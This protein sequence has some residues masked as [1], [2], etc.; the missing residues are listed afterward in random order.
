MTFT[1]GSPASVVSFMLV[2][3]AVIGAYIWGTFTA[4]RREGG[5]TAA[6]RA[7]WRFVV[8]TAVWLAAFTA[9]VGSGLLQ[10]RPLPFGPLTLICVNVVALAFALSSAGGRLARHV[11]LVALVAFQG[12]RLPLELVLHAWSEQGVI[13]VA[14]T[15][16]GSNLDIIS[17][18]VALVLAP[19]AR[20]PAVAWVANGIGLALLANV[21][22]VAIMTSPV[23]F[24]W[25]VEPKLM[26]VAYLPY[27]YIGPVCVAGALAGHVILTRKLLGRD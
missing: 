12:F 7:T 20:R 17:G 11:P 5:A 18:I 16:T 23:P 14:M 21:A 25:P 19:F 13:P 9:W 15:W 27:A 8:G 26:L 2:V 1:P 6:Q 24:G 4:A 22:R 3:A 10:A